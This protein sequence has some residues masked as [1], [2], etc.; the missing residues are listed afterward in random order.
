M[1]SKQL[2][3]KI[4]WAINT[5]FLQIVTGQLYQ[6]PAVYSKGK[7]TKK[8]LFGVLAL[9]SPKWNRKLLTCLPFLSTPVHSHTLAWLPTLCPHAK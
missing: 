7:G 3:K 1:L 8:V 6:G 2:R 5:T 4:K 9:T